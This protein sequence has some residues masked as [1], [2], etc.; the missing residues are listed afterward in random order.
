MDNS[1][2]F[3]GFDLGAQKKVHFQQCAA[4]AAKAVVYRTVRP[5][6]GLLADELME[7]LEAR[8]LS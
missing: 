5:N 4:M 3:A 2:N 1:G 7:M 6:K 8:F